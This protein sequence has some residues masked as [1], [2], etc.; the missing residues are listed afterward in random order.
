MNCAGVICYN[1]MYTLFHKLY[2]ELDGFKKCIN[3]NDYVE[4]SVEYDYDEEMIEFS[5]S[6]VGSVRYD[7]REV[8]PDEDAVSYVFPKAFLC[9]D[10]KSVKA[11]TGG[12][13][14][15]EIEE[16]L[17]YSVAPFKGQDVGYPHALDVLVCDCNKHNFIDMP[18]KYPKVVSNLRRVVGLTNSFDILDP[19]EGVTMLRIFN[20][21]DNLVTDLLNPCIGVVDRFTYGSDNIFDSALLHV[22]NGANSIK[23]CDVDNIIILNKSEESVRLFK[24]PN[25]RYTLIFG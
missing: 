6:G 20:D 1:D 17:E 13:V 19:K 5:I 15:D 25:G 14:V 7:Y 11:Y 16:G 24:K 3:E 10:L 4:I 12:V 18:I 22:V 9:K 8:C 2:K 23:N 21:G